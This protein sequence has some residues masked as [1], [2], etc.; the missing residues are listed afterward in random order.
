M[1][2]AN[3]VHYVVVGLQ[4]FLQQEPV[5]IES[6]AAIQDPQVT[7]IA[8]EVQDNHQQLAAQIQKMQATVQAI[9]LQYAAPQ[10]SYQSYGGADTTEETTVLKSAEDVV[11]NVD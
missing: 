1:H 3:L 11:T 4:E 8:N 5:P 7:H 9:Q 10:P 2:H 6:H